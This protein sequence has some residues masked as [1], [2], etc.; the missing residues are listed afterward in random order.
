MAVNK[1][2]LSVLLTASACGHAQTIDFSLGAWLDLSHAYAEDTLY[3][4]TAS[5]FRKDTV[6]EGETPGGW[7]YTAYD[8]RTAEHG[9]THIDAPI[10]FSAGRHTVDRVPLDSLIGAGVVVDVSAQALANPDYQL[11][12]AD[13]AEWEAV[14]GTIAPGA[15]V[16]V[17]TG[18]AGFWPNAEKYLGTAERGAGAVP[19]LHFPG[20]HP[21]AAR[22]L[23]ERGIAAVGLDTASVDYGQSTDFMT[24]R[25][26]YEANIPG[27]ENVGDLSGL[28][29]TGSFIVAL[30]MK[31][32]GGSGAPLRIAA[33]VPLE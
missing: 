32:E 20:I 15:I 18:Y 1:T 30:P 9:G 10:H 23:V 3:W 29:A 8:I 24:H 28:P 7:Y 19:L 14:H 5:T 21:G 33:F 11:S 25:V 16:L 22:V 27:F 31:I 12:A 17:R 13:L 4:P 26:L 2:M 6:F